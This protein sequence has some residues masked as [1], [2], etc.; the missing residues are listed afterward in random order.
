MV[1]YSSVVSTWGACTLGVI[2]RNLGGGGYEKISYINQNET[3]EP[4]GP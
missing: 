3:Q 1:F 4:L 2:R